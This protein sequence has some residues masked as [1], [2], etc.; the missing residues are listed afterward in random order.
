MT[1]LNK[2]FKKKRFNQ[3]KTESEIYA[4]MGSLGLSCESMLKYQEAISKIK[5]FE[6]R[7]GK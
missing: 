4:Y 3:F 7:H 2:L 5:Y 1:F 6:E